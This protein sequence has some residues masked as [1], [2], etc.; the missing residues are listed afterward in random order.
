MEDTDEWGGERNAQ[1]RSE[2]FFVLKRRNNPK[3]TE[4]GCFL[5]HSQLGKSE[6]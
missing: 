1:E 3:V 2:D 5:S 6:L 4:F